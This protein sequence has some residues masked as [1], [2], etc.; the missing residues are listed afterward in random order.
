MKRIDTQTAPTMPGAP[1]PTKR[2]D[3]SGFVGTYLDPAEAA[4]FAAL[5]RRWGL[6]QTDTIKRMIRLSDQ[7][8]NM[9]A[10]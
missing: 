10:G 9:T 5:R 6:N 2:R 3:R 7:I 4:T 1:P 8:T